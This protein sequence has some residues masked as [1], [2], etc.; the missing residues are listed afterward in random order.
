MRNELVWKQKRVGASDIVASARN[1][2]DQWRN[3][4]KS[5][6]EISWP[7]FQAGDGAEQWVCPPE[8]SVKIN[9]D[10]ALFDNGNRAGVG[11]V[12]RDA[13]GLF[14]DGFVRMFYEALDPTLVET[15]GVR[16]ALSWLKRSPRQQAFVETDCLTVVQAIRSQVKMISLFGIVISECKVLIQELKNVSICF[17]KRSANMVAHTLPR[18]SILYLDRSFSLGDVPTDLL[19]YLVVEFAG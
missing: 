15:M 2:L 14:I 13:N 6:I 9:V 16:E 8:N 18:A 10:A 19:P 5:Q 7:G 3:A 17:V 12:I 4:Q 11:V 1:Y